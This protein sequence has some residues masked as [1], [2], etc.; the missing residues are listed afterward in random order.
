M[1][2]I[3][4]DLEHYIERHSDEVPEILQQLERETW[5]KIIQFK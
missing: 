4:E 2:F 5:Q 1:H 3:S